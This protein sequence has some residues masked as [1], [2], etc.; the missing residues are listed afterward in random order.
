MSLWILFLYTITVNVSL[1]VTL[2]YCFILF[3][4]RVSVNKYINNVRQLWVLLSYLFLK[5]V[6]DTLRIFENLNCQILT[7]HIF[8]IHIIQYLHP[9]NA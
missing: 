4:N 6:S 8:T 7:T 2:Y 5:E 3:Q 9:S 1:F